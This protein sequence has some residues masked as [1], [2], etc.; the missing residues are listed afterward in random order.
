MGFDKGHKEFHRLEMQTAWHTPAGYPAGIQQKIIAGD[1]DEK[2]KR[3]NGSLDMLEK[4]FLIAIEDN[5][6]PELRRGNFVVIGRLIHLSSHYR[7][8]VRCARR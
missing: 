6:K 1:L 3:S 7:K 8:S 2:N 5:I 4:L